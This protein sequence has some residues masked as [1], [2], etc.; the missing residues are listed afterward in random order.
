MTLTVPRAGL[1][2]GRAADERADTAGAFGGLMADLGDRMLKMG[3]RIRAE[4]DDLALQRAN[5][6]IARDLGQARLEVSQIGDPQEMGETWE[7]RAAEI[8]AR[9]IEAIADPALRERATLAFDGLNDRH[10][11]AVGQDAIAMTRAQRTAQ[12]QEMQGGIT[13]EAVTA[14]PETLAAFLE[15]GDE[16]IARRLATGDIDAAQAQRERA[17]FRSEIHGARAAA[18]V[19]RDP[20]GFLASQDPERDAALGGDT[21]TRLRL[22]AEREVARRADA[23]Q[24]D[25]EAAAKARD[26]EIGR[27]LADIT[28]LAHDGLKIT[29]E[30]LLD[31]VKDHPGYP[32]AAAAIALRDEMPAI[33]A[34]TPPELSAAITAEEA[35]PKTRPFQAERLKVLRRWHDEAVA[36][37]SRDGPGAA[38]AAGLTVPDL[39]AFDPQRPGDLARGLAARLAF[40]GW[41]RER[42]WP[43]QAVLSPGER[44]ELKAVLAPEADPAPKLALAEAVLSGAGGDWRRVAGLVEA[45]PAFAGALRLLDDTGDRDAALAVFRGQQKLKLGTVGAP[46]PSAQRLILADAL[47]DALPAGRA[48][49]VM[50]AAAAIYADQAGAIN[51]EGADSVVPFMSDTDAQDLFRRAVA[52]ASGATPDAGGELTVGGVQPVAGHPLLLPP[53]LSAADA[54]RAW[55]DAGQR[56]RGYLPDPASRGGR[57]NTGQVNTDLLRAASIDGALP[58]LGDDPW[59]RWGQLRMQAVEGRPGE[60]RMVYSRNGRDWPVARAGDPTGTA[61]HFRLSDLARE[62]GR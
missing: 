51:P 28:R 38:R 21:L 36:Q 53:G 47:G 1:T 13:A 45:D 30:G 39:P 41:T 31:Q 5:L 23:A 52:R 42:G 35:A 18:D 11:L 46:P 17:A 43:G 34:M 20:E 58:D 4:R 3:Q 22:S 37:W 24:K 40:D 57:I 8:R 14:D 16:A 26:A 7:A 44:A 15:L 33:R 2:G 60:Y 48:A 9:H 10:S 59:T 54:N 27:R 56:L 62:A 29:D 32:E 50:A 55:D 49:E 61:W 12:W 19:Q 6:D 25:A